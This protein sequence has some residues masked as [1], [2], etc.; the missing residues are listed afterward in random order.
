MPLWLAWILAAACAALAL[1]GG[2][3]ALR[4]EAARPESRAP[5]PGF[6]EFGAGLAGI[7]LLIPRLFEVYWP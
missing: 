2:W 4:A 1:R 7:A 5:R 3:R 6:V